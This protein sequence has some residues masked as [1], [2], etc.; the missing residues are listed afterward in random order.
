MRD[1]YEYRTVTLVSD[2]G[3]QST[4]ELMGTYQEV[5][6]SGRKVIVECS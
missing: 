2:T 4:N 1:K 6:D 5:S 3:L